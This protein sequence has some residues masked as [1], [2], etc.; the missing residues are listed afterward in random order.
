VVQVQYEC[1]G[2]VWRE[3]SRSKHSDCD[4]TCDQASAAGNAVDNSWFSYYDH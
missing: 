2:F 4:A 1:A 3:T